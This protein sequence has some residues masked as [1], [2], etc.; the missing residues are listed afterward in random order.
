[1]KKWL[2]PVAMFA[3]FGLGFQSNSE[4]APV[5][6][7]SL[8][9]IVKGKADLKKGKA[10]KVG[11]Q[12]VLQKNATKVHPQAPFKCKVSASAGIALAKKK[13]G[14]DDKKI[15]KDKKQVD[16]AIGVTASKAGNVVMD[17]SFFVCTKDICARTEEQVK[18]AAKVK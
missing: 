2:L 17:C 7:K 18:I 8:Y 14:H 16:V 10:G 3:M 1:M 15:S 6:V 4:A 13:L 12:I 5:K 11:F 9:K